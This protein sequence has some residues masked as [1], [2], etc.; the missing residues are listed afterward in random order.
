MADGLDAQGSAQGASSAQDLQAQFDKLRADYAASSSEAKR[1]KQERDF[2]EQQA[3]QA[4]VIPPSQ[5]PYQRLQ[6]EG[7]PVE[8]LSQWVD[9][10]ADKKVNDRLSPLFNTLNARGQVLQE[11][12]DFGKFEPDV[13]KFV[14]EDPARQQRYNSLLQSDPA[15]AMDWA[16]TK[17]E[18]SQ[19]KTAAQNGSNKQSRSDASI[20]SGQSNANRDS[21]TDN[22]MAEVAKKAMSEF[23]KT[24]DK[25]AAEAY[26]RARLRSLIPDSF[27]DIK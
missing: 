23:Q 3:R 5:D 19:R 4:P 13:M 18:S 16:Y 9:Q 6:N 24:G 2:F 8:A 11:N 22:G 20:P 17:F 26:G 12:P 7:W 25:R 21:A 15:A 14:A 27:Y 10:V 1:L